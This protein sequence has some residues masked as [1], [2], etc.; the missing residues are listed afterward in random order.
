[1]IYK[2]ENEGVPMGVYFDED[3]SIYRKQGDNIAGIIQ[4]ITQRYIGENP[5]HPVTY[6]SYCTRGIK[7]LRDYCYNFCLDQIFPEAKPETIVYAWAKLW[8][9]HETALNLVVSGYGPVTVYCNGREVFKSNIINERFLDYKSVIKVEVERGWNSFVLKFTKTPAGFG[10]LFGSASPK[11]LPLHFVMASLEREG[12]EGWL[13]TQPLTAGLK[14]LPEI[15]ISEKDIGL[16]WAPISEWTDSER[17]MGQLGRLFGLETGCAA[18]GW[19]KAYFSCPGISEYSLQGSC[20]GPIQVFI[21]ANEIYSSECSGE[22]RAKIK[23]PYGKHDLV[24]I[25]RCSGTDWGFQLDLFQGSETVPLSSP[26]PVQGGTEVWLYAGPFLNTSLPGLNEICR[27][28]RV[29]HGKNGACYWRLDQPGVSI[30]PYLENRNFGKWNY[31]LGV[32]LYGLLQA[33]RLLNSNT[34]IDYVLKHVD[35]AVSMFHYAFWDQEQYGAA[36]VLHQLTTIDSLDDC[37]S[38][39]SLMLEALQHFQ[40]KECYEIADFI[41]DFISNK[42]ERLEDGAFYRK[43][44]FHSFM[45]DTLWADD[46]YMSVPFLCR[47]YQLTGAAKYIDDA[48]GQLLRY[49]RYLYLPEQEI[50]S[51]VYD[52]KIGK[53]TGV[54]WGR[55]NGWVAFSFSE[56]LAVLPNNHPDRPELLQIFNDLCDG[57]LALQ[58]ETGMWHQVLTDTQSYLETSCTAMFI[59]AFSRGVRFGWLHDPERYLQAAIKGWYGLTRIAV[60]EQGNIYGVCRGSGFSFT[61]DYYKNDLPW[62]LNDT[63]GIGIVLLAGVEL[64]KT[65]QTLAEVPGNAGNYWK[66]TGEER[67]L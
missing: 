37:G 20:T 60:D 63:H 17:K 16:K 52:V 7:R 53:A 39:G 33:G 67:E 48:A 25:C 3:L 41:A 4:T 19:T 65:A 54:P 51:H 32:T 57:Y 21:G 2:K 5:P 30:R 66:K 12:Q 42:Q 61:A 10:G 47:Y 45:E 8:S 40:K 62:V 31:P 59:Y 28:D 18:I 6:R 49:R 1:M 13:F 29:F 43:H 26:I 24:V 14:E 27:M 36:G 55:G 38:F 58:D 11:S 15:G 35:L 34:V 44:S 46:L 64:L 50:M 9:D 23:V 22:F 56:L